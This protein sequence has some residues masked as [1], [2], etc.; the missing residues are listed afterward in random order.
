MV[1]GSSKAG[2]GGVLR[3]NRGEWV[4]GY[5]KVIGVC[6]ACSA[7]EWAVLEGLKLAWDFGVKNVILESDAQELIRR[8][9]APSSH[10]GSLLFEQIRKMLR[11]EWQVNL[12]YI[13]REINR[14]A[15]ALAK[16]GISRTA[17]LGNCPA[18]LATWLEQDAL[19]FI[20]Y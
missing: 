2:C 12:R 1:I 4:I 17:V 19:G 16:L 18:R 8:I 5:T 7:E 11:R 20:S 3:N 10:P 13:P 15:D 6:D 9:T 14:L